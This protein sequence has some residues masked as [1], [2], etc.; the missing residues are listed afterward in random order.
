[1]RAALGEEASRRAEA[2]GRA[3]ALDDAVALALA[4]A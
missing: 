4:D 2:E 1:V 3:L